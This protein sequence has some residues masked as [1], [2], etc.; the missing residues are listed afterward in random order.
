[1]A[2]DTINPAIIAAIAKAIDEKQ[3]KAA[4]PELQEGSEIAIDALIQLTGSLT[5]GKSATTTSVASLKPW[6]LFL[7]A[8]SMLNGVSIEKLISLADDMAEA[9]EKAQKEKVMKAAERLKGKVQIVRA[10]SIKFK[11]L[12]EVID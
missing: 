1:M 6:C 8:L 5:V 12:V 3:L 7:A 11:G 9:D 10:G 4:R 2:T